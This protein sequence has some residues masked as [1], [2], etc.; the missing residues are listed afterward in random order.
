MASHLCHDSSMSSQHADPALTVRPPAAVT[1]QAQAA[2]KARDLKMRAFVT[3]CL[4][5]FN[6]DPDGFLDGLATHWPADKPRGRPPRAT[7]IPDA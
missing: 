2:L 7:G 6:T 4:Q 3:A 5:A 1:A